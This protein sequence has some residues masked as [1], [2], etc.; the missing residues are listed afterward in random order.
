MRFRTPEQAAA[1]KGITF[2]LVL[3]LVVAVAFTVASE[4]SRPSSG[5]E[6]PWVVV[7]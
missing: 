1:E 7:Q 6:L 5:T 3:A 2:L 4:R